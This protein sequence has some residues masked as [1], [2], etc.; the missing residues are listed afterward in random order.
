MGASEN[1]I[2]KYNVLKEQYI[3]EH[4]EYNK[5]SN[6]ISLFRLLVVIGFGSTIY[7]YISTNNSAW[8]LF[9]F[10]LVPLFLFLVKYH[11]RIS[12]QKTFR[13]T[14]STINEEEIDYLENKKMP[15][16]DGSS[17][18]NTSH[19]YS[20]DLD[21]FGEKS[22]F[23]ILNRTG[24]YIGETKLAK[25]L[26]TLLPNQEIERNQKA[27]E[28]LSETLEIRQKVYAIAKMTEDS[29]E[30]WNK[31]TQWS[32]ISK[33]EVSVFYVIFSYISPV[34]LILSLIAYYFDVPFSFPIT[35]GLFFINLLM[36]R[37]QLKNIKNELLGTSKM[38]NTVKNYSRI[39]KMMEDYDFK[40]DKLNALKQQLNTNGSTASEEIKRLSDLYYKLENIYN[41]IGT[42]LFNGLFLYHLHTLRAIIKWKNRNGSQMLN[43]LDSIAEFEML[44]SLANFS[45]NNPDFNYPT[46]NNKNEISFTNLGHPLISKKER[47]TNNVSFTNQNFIILTGSN[48]SGKS[49][50]LR[51]LGVNMILARTGAPI[52]ADQANIHPL[53]ICVSMRLSD[54]LNDSE[55]YFFAEVKRLKEIMEQADAVPS[56]ILLDEIL[57]GTNSDDKRTGTV[58]VIKKIISKNVIGAIAT[59]DLKVCDIT[60]DYPI[61]LVNKCF[62]VEIINNDLFFDYKLREGVC[63]NKSATFLMKK[64]EVI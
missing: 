32:S 36:L 12:F 30:L 5:R 42:L 40:S 10:G 33:Q 2:K 57:R 6:I 48:M 45:F 47:V 4:N 56:F 18:I 21:I 3:S 9:T 25:A 17:Y 54:S 64:M 22:I 49:T 62:E 7:Y 35:L 46:I 1:N 34:S 16:N 15:F 13:K 37:I 29:S 28:E 53:N 39:M 27:V 11:G 31:I 44:S 41:P 50:F 8:L 51:S 43:W 14:L 26:L 19:N 59:H 38:H 55:S 63:K 60:K 61:Q 24:T 20:Y 52:C 58:E 23:Q